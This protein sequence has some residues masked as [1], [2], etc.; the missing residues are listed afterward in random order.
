M[1]RYILL[2]ISPVTATIIII[3]F[4]MGITTSFNIVSYV[5]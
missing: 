2:D 1:Y 5:L 3:K 4:D